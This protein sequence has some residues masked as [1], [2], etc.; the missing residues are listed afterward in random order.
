MEQSNEKNVI[1][2]DN[3]NN[4]TNTQDS[5][6]PKNQNNN[7]DPLIEKL[8]RRALID[9]YESPNTLPNIA[10]SAELENYGTNFGVNDQN[11]NRNYVLRNSEEEEGYESDL[12]GYFLRR[13]Y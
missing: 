1:L 6:Q 5:I 9:S 10:I 2:Q 8:N 12:T 3:P 11:L 13:L 7:E 4:Q